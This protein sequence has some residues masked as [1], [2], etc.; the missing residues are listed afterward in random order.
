MSMSVTR[1][2][3]RKDNNKTNEG[4]LVKGIIID[5]YGNIIRKIDED[6]YIETNQGNYWLVLSEKS[7]KYGIL[8]NSGN[9]ILE[10]E[11][12][13]I[14]YLKENMVLAIK[15]NRSYMAVVDLISGNRFEIIDPI[16]LIKR[17]F[18]KL[19]NKT[20][21]T[22]KIECSF[23]GAFH[24]GLVSVKIGNL[25][26][27]V[28]KTGKMVIE[29]KYKNVGYFSDGLA[30]IKENGLYG[31]INQTGKIV[32]EPK[33]E[34][35]DHFKDGIARVK[36]G[37]SWIIINKVGEE[38][39]PQVLCD[40]IHDFEN[41]YAVI[42]KDRCYG[43]IDVKGNE[44]IKCEYKFL[45]YN[46]NYPYIIVYK[47]TG[48]GLMD[49]K[50]NIIC[51][52]IYK[53]LR[54]VDD[55]IIIDEE[56]YIYFDEISYELVIQKGDNKITKS[57]DNVESR[58]KYYELVWEEIQKQNDISNKKRIAL[59]VDIEQKRKKIEEV[60]MERKCILEQ[61]INDEENTI[62]QKIKTLI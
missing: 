61:Q 13:D 6:L 37:D 46:S 54:I 50:G 51:D 62:F 60:S 59:D 25:Y 29:P 22:N 55:K 3:A 32:I 19:K 16:P 17:V 27:F 56:K 31:F 52:C 30:L 20:N 44:I 40:N 48:Y 11:Y 38:I 41:G 45:T 49:I 53:S 33:Y 15:E 21:N 18:N 5:K 58:E 35:A 1:K 10:C 39:E 47:K 12:T 36:K 42:R 26:G 7:D 14:E 28:D 34:L 9:K 57:F 4:L 23:I 8:D 2:L 24:D 43:L